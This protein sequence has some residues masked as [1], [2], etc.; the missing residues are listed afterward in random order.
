MAG[1]IGLD[2]PTMQ[3]IPGGLQAQFLRYSMQPCLFC[4]FMYYCLSSKW[5][6]TGMSLQ[7]SILV[8]C[9]LVKESLHS[10]SKSFG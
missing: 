10:C 5:E 4:C 1:Q 6:G 8:G 9:L 7:G 2:P 3:L